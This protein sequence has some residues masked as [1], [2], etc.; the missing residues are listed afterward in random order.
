MEDEH[1]RARVLIKELK[2]DREPY[3]VR[4]EKNGK[5]KREPNRPVGHQSK[6]V[7]PQEANKS[8]WKTTLSY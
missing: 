5:C 6:H 2:H 4:T 1:G 7:V 3:T 8:I